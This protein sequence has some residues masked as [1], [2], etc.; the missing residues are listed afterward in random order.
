MSIENQVKQVVAVKR[1]ESGVILNPITLPN[2][3]TV[4]HAK[5]IMSDNN[6]GGVPILDQDKKLVGIVTTRD[7][8][9]EKN[10]NQTVDKIMTSQ[11]LITTD[12]ST[13]LEKAESILQ[14]KKIEKLPVVDTSKNLIGLITYRDIMKVKEQPTACKD[15]LGRLF[16]V[17]EKP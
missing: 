11:N 8:R 4:S 10:L 7:L 16:L 3:A 17:T 12:R 13:S 14:E 15:S 6:I 1:S 9:F 5:K 2:P